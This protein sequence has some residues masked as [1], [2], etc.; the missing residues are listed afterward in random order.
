MCLHGG[1]GVGS[2]PRLAQYFDPEKFRIVLHD[3]RGTG[4]SKPFGE[5][6]GNTTGELVEDIEKLRQHLSIDKFLLFGGS[7]G[8]TLGLAYAEKYPH[9][10][11]GMVLRGIFLGTPEEVEFHYV[12]TGC[13]FPEEYDRLCTLLPNPEKGAYPEQWHPLIHGDDLKRREEILDALVRFEL[14]FMTLEMP[15]ATIDGFLS[16]I[17]KQ[18]MYLSA[19]IDHHYVINGYFLKDNQLLAQIGVLKD[20]PITLING[21]YDMAAPPRAAFLV[22]KALP[23][24][25]L[26]WVEGAGHSERESGITEALLNAV[27]KFQ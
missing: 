25:E 18:A 6:K 13:F 3:Q 27:K 20:I 8:S 11:T 9:R 22:H 24:S 5:L 23:K 4:Q 2:Y 17:P 7:W 26:I 14:K 10:I 16:S 21:R 1:P 12:R 19:R 15:D